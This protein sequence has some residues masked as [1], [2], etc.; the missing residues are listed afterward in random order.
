MKLKLDL[1]SK[2]G[3]Y[4]FRGFN[5]YLKRDDLINPHFSGNKA[6]KLYYLLKGDFRGINRVISYGSIQSNAMYSLSVL[7]KAKGWRFEYYIDH[8]PNYLRDN[9]SGNYKRALENSTT[10][11]EYP[12][13][14]Q[15]GLSHLKIDKDTILIAEG[16]RER[17]ASLGIELLANE[18]RR[19][20]EQNSIDRLNIFLPSGTGTTALYLQ[21]YLKDIRVITTP[22]VGDSN[23]LIE[24]FKLLE[25]D[26]EAF[27]EVIDTKK[28][29]HFGKL[30][31]EFYQLWL[32]LYRDIGVEFDM[33][34]DPKGW[35]SLLDILDSL[36]GELLYIHQGGIIGNESMLMRYRRKYPNLEKEILGVKEYENFRY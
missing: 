12:K 28:R 2:I 34:Y 26:K 21:K 8:I 35:L 25:D 1:P 30:Y 22:C 13:V 20:Q 10:F 29:Y 17:G 31:R 3:R 9:P 27:P 36:E 16:A 32:E 33:L 7:A 23:Y 18:I 15:K 4:N 14:S 19:W 24:Q 6:R 11:I 5:F